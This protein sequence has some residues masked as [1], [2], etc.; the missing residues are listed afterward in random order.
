MESVEIFQELAKLGM[1]FVLMGIAVLYMKNQKDK[2][3]KKVDDLEKE[4]KDYSKD[5]RDLA[6]NS[7]KVLTLVD[8]KLKSDILN[9]DHVREIHRM[10]SEILEIEKKRG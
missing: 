4:L 1:V 3:D 8:D 10:V 5:Y 7:L 9:N 6:N 2:A